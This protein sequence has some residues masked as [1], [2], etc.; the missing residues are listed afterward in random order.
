M[1]DFEVRFQVTLS[2]Q[3]GKDFGP[4]AR[5]AFLRAA[6]SA[7][8]VTETQIQ[9]PQVRGGLFVVAEV[10]VTGIPDL[11]GAH[12]AAHNAADHGGLYQVGRGTGI[13]SQHACSSVGGSKLLLHGVA[14]G[15]FGR[16]LGA[17]RRVDPRAGGDLGLRDRPS[18]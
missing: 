6:A 2:E 3:K 14:P 13:T 9:V 12:R 7:L 10:R 11:Q 15:L 18:R 5:A 1:G 4:P 8:E 16:G 17:V